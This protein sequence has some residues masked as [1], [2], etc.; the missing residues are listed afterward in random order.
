[1]G[2]DERH[3][4]R[5]RVVQGAHGLADGA[6]GVDHVVDD[7]AVTALHLADDAMRNGVV[8][9]GDVARLVDE[10]E[11][12]TAELRGPLLGN[13]DAA[14]IWRDDGGVLQRHVAPHVV[15]QD[16]HGGQMVDRAVEESL[17]LR[18][19]QVDRHDAVRAGGAEQ[20]EHQAGGDGLAP[21]VLLVLTGI[22][23]ERGDHGDGTRG[24]ALHGVH[25]DEL[26]HD[27]LVDRLGVG[28]HDEGVGAT[29][30]L[31]VAHVHLTVGEIVGGGLQ[32][33][34]AEIFR[35]FHGLF[36]VCT[37]RH[38]RQFL[39]RS[40]FENRRHASPSKCSVREIKPNSNITM[41]VP[42]ACSSHDSTF[43]A[44]Y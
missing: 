5:A 3:G 27:P 30:R 38:Q 23:K 41:R 15:D 8:R 16:R 44:K 2:G 25:H 34:G 11:R 18:G 21:L 10:R 7:H 32:N 29:H 13:L 19:M 14:G 9:T 22:A 12:Q 4:L 35:G 17:L 20:V 33:V 36:G 43:A 24:G 31:G 42:I 1:M 6:G 26:F 40:A 28:L 39:I 37:T